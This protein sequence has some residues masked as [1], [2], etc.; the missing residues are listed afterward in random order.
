MPLSSA[1]PLSVISFD[2][3]SKKRKKITALL[4]ERLYHLLADRDIPIG[5][6]N[7]S[8]PS[9]NFR[10]EFDAADIFGFREPFL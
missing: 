5:N 6:V 7:L 9:E 1:H 10:S 4:K 3:Y 2:I 8:R